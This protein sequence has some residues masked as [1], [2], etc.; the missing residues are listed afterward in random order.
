LPYEYERTGVDLGY[1]FARTLSLVGGFGW[2]SDLD[3]STTAGGLDS[4]YWNAGLRYVPNERTSAEGRYGERFFGSSWSLEVSHRARMLE[5]NASYSEEPTV[6]T[7]TLALPE[8]DPGQLP[9]GFPGIDFGRLNSS[10][11]IARDARAGVRAVGSR[12]TLGL[13]AYQYERDYLR[14][15]R[16]DETYTGV[17][18]GATRQLGSNLSADFGLSWSEYE[19]SF[20]ATPTDPAADGTYDDVQATL[21]VNR[22]SGEKLTLSAEAGYLTRSGDQD[23]YDGWWT[24]LRARWTP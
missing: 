18:L 3:A 6:E 19:Q 14:A 11:Y 7:R 22:K 5:F 20:A 16:T 12:T 4:E 8:F 21:R 15:A 17:A 13:T 24:G 9:P 10:P 2:E 1:R 23:D